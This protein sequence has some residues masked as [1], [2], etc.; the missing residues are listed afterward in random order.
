MNCLLCGSLSS[1]ELF[2]HYEKPLCLLCAA[3]IA[4]AY[5]K[6]STK[7]QRRQQVF[8]RF[9]KLGLRVMP[10]DQRILEI[11]E[12]STDEQIDGAI[13]I[14]KKSNAVSLGY[15][16]AI[17]RSE[18]TRKPAKAEAKEVEPAQ[19]VEKKEPWEREGF[20]SEQD[21]LK[22]QDA[23]TKMKFKQQIGKGQKWPEFRAS[24]LAEAL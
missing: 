19:S 1:T 8:M 24:W 20:V 18:R 14:A 11:A 23:F 10:T 2:T 12:N 3:D 15:I 4:S 5:H 17:L 6:C 7:P 16:A 22:C 13:E 21:Y 9:T